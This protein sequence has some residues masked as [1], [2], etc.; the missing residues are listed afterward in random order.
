MMI[1]LPDVGTPN[2]RWFFL[3]PIS[4]ALKD[5]FPYCLGMIKFYFL[6]Q[7]HDVTALFLRA[8]CPDSTSNPRFKTRMS[9]SIGPLNTEIKAKWTPGGISISSN[10]PSQG[11]C[12]PQH[13]L[14]DLDF[15]AVNQTVSHWQSALPMSQPFCP[16]P[17]YF[18][19]YLTPVQSA[20]SS[21]NQIPRN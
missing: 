2:L 10:E 1:M 18:T 15:C 7:I 16:L 21:P 11:G 9:F 6:A 14:A 5:L 13:F 19:F 20:H 4:E 3:F 8:L 17:R 12:P